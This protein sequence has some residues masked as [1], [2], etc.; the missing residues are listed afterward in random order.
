[1]NFLAVFIFLTMGLFASAQAQR[2]LVVIDQKARFDISVNGNF[3]AHPE[4]REVLENDLSQSGV[5]NVIAGGSEYIANAQYVDNGVMGS[6]S[7]N[8]SSMFSKTFEGNWRHATHLFADAIVEALTGKP[9]FASSKVVFI[10]AQTGSKEVYTMDIDGT[11]VHQITNDH[12]LSLGPKFSPDGKKIAY[13]SYKSNYP[14]VWV[15]NLAAS[16]RKR[17]SYFPGLNSQPAFSPDESRI[18]LVLSKDGNTE[19]YT[20]DPNGGNLIRLTHTRGTEASPTWSPDGSELA[21][22]SDDR[23]LTQ[24]YTMPSSG[25]PASRVMVN[26][27]YATEPD[28]SLDGDKLVYSVRMGGEFQIAMTNLKTHQCTLLTSAGSNESPSWARDSRHIVYEHGGQ[29]YLLDSLTKQ[30]VLIRNGLKKNSE[31]NCSR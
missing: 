11:N 27:S 30:S 26:A 6:L 21:F 2:P 12:T 14:D 19:L 18:A 1:M 10:S 31:P 15:I 16:N 28:W 25:G 8:G 29:L 4:G 7:K 17:V 20:M 3:S 23:G 9:G 5:F 22:V 13:T 24:I